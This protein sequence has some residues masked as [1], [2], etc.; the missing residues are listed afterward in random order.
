MEQRGTPT[1]E[2]DRGSVKDSKIF[3]TSLGIIAHPR[4]G[5]A[6]PGSVEVGLLES[7][8]AAL[9]LLAIALCLLAIALCIS[10]LP[11]APS[12]RIL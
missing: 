3:L 8:E 9:C 10:G 2:D 1:H 6:R 7:Q 5:T 11:C 12:Q 4:G